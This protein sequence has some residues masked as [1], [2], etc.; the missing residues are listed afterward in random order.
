MAAIRRAVIASGIAGRVRGRQRRL[1]TGHP[2]A[3]DLGTDFFTFKA[4]M[5]CG[6]AS[7]LFDFFL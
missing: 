3:E 2:T 4:G 1:S 5:G 6:M 7:Y